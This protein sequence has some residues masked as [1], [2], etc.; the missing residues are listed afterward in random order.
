MKQVMLQ[1]NTQKV[2]NAGHMKI[3]SITFQHLLKQLAFSKLGT[4]RINSGYQT[5]LK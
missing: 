1:T 3:P 5:F 4:T 2:Y